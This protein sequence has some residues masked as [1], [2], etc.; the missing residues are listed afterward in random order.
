MQ[1]DMFPHTV[2][3]YHNPNGEVDSITILRGTLLDESPTAEV[4]TRGYSGVDKAVLY[5]PFQVKALDGLTHAL[6]RYAAPVEFEQAEGKN[7]LWTF[8]PGTS[9]FVKGE[10]V[11][12]DMDRQQIEEKHP[13]VYEVVSVA[14]R[15]FGSP[16][17]RHW[18]VG[19]K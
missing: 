12:P 3:I 16:D 4:S 13:S 6:K 17:M 9:F 14:T 19:G 2:T 8:F 7:S 10:V 11:E 18:E 15:D 1:T 5:V